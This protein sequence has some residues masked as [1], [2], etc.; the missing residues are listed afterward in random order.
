MADVFLS[1]ASEDRERIREL[2]SALEAADYSV[3]WDR[4]IVPGTSF[5]P[6]IEREIAAARCIVVLWS[7]ASIRSQWVQGEA[8]EG[9]D[10]RILVPVML[11]DVRPPL[12]FRYQDAADFRDWK[13]QVQ[14]PEFIRLR[15]GIDAAFGGQAAVDVKQLRSELAPRRSRGPLS[16]VAI[17]SVFVLVLLAGFYWFQF[18]R[19]GVVERHSVAVAE[20]LNQASGKADYLGFGIA[21]QVRDLLG[22]IERV[23]VASR[24]S[25]NAASTID[26]VSLGELLGVRYFV[27]GSIEGSPQG[28]QIDVHLVNT[29]TGLRVWTKRYRGDRERLLDVTYNIALD[30]AAEMGVEISPGAVTR[31]QARPSDSP[32]AWEQYLIG[33]EL[34]QRPDVGAVLTEAEEAFTQALQHDVNFAHAYAGLCQVYLLRYR[35]SLDVAFFQE[36]EQ[37]CDETIR[38]DDLQVDPRVA[39]GNLYLTSGAFERAIDSFEV[40]IELAPTAPEPLIGLGQAYEGSG[41]SQRA[42]KWYRN[43]IGRFPAFW[44]ARARL[45]TLLFNQGRFADAIPV[46]AEVVVLSPQSSTAF[47]NLGAANFMQGNF[48]EALSA[49]QAAQKLHDDVLARL[50]TGTAY[51]FLGRVEEARQMYELATQMSARDHR[52]WGQLGDAN[53]LLGAQDL[54]DAAYKKA[55]EL[56]RLTLEVNPRDVATT[57]EIAGYLAYLGQ[58]DAAV[59]YIKTALD[60]GADDLYVHYEITVAHLRLN[61]TGA[62]RNAINRAIELGYPE[63]LAK[64]DPQLTALD[65]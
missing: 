43:A 37:N 64:A 2:V 41:D 10:R 11:D 7:H 6:E 45:G 20:F 51:F 14:H 23:Q 17:S 4:A 24:T 13:G 22:R 56:A 57:A 1:Y 60:L 46:Y 59:D 12:L 34:L 48:S 40:A 42:E 47:V 53:S 55:V 16:A 3:W 61:N 33:S 5:G 35:D 39:L 27:E 32:Q 18:A 8:A 63:N 31:L 54:A 44:H 15:E 65:L 50:N 30:I 26:I 38:L 9:L 36:A 62:A 28:F 19:V 52:A 49:W 58:T 21:R 25:T 29:N